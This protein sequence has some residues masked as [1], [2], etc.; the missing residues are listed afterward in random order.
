MLLLIIVFRKWHDLRVM[1][2]PVPSVHIVD[3]REDSAYG[4]WV[5]KSPMKEQTEAIWEERR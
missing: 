3:Q 2:F 4:L 5:G 1:P